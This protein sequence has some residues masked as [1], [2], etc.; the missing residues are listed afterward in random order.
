MEGKLGLAGFGENGTW[1]GILFMVS[2]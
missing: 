2:R 1:K